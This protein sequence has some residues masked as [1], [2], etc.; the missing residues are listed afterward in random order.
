MGRAASRNFVREETSNV[1]RTSAVNTLPAL[2][3]ECPW[4]KEVLP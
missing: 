4:L 2:P 1:M 3:V